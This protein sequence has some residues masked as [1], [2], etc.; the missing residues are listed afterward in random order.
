[1]HHD[2]MSVRPWIINFILIVPTEQTVDAHTKLPLRTVL[3]PIYM[4]CQVKSK[5]FAWENSKRK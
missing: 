3:Q 4:G 5:L 2:A 1:M